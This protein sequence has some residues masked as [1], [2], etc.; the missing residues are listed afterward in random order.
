MRLQL[1]VASHKIWKTSTIDI[2]SAFLKGEKIDRRVI[3][4]PPICVK[5]N[6]KWLLKKCVYGLRKASRR[7]YLKLDEALTQ[8]G[9]GNI[10]LDEGV[11]VWR[12]NGEFKGMVAYMLMI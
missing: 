5:T 9:L 10:S 11:Y 4:K 3:L 1:I 2:K 6:K 7:W 12:K 8:L